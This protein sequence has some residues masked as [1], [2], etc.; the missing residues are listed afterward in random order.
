[1]ESN[2]ISVKEDLPEYDTNVLMNVLGTGVCFG[3][4]Y[5]RRRGIVWRYFTKEGFVQLKNEAFVTHW[6]PL[7]Q[8]PNSL[9]TSTIKEGI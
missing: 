5:E 4:L 7:P 9:N 8:P 3:A 2:W 1:M 6:M